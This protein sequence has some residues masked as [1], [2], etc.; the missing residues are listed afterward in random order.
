MIAIVACDMRWRR[1][2]RRS[3][4]GGWADSSG[5]N[6]EVTRLQER[7]IPVL[8]PANPLR[9]LESDADYVRSVLQTIQGPIALVGHSYSGAL[10][11]SA[12][13][14]VPNVKGA[15]HRWVRSG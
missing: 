15:G 5:W 8:A 14:G 11:T 7:G 6:Q 1:C 13:V 4:H 12:A 3:A 10:I 2:N 9:G